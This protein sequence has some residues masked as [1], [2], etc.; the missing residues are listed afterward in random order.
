MT[1]SNEPKLLSVAESNEVHGIITEFNLMDWHVQDIHDEIEKLTQSGQS[2]D[3]DIVTRIEKLSIALA[4]CVKVAGDKY[5]ALND[6]RIEKSVA[7]ALMLETPNEFNSFPMG[8]FLDYSEPTHK[9]NVGD[10]VWA[11]FALTE[12]GE[13][14]SIRAVIVGKGIDLDDVYY[15]VAPYTEKMDVCV[16]IARDFEEDELS[17]ED[18]D[19][20]KKFTVVK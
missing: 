15:T 16:P 19:P 6:H 1:P 2:S 14:M 10:I 8:L 13:V 18:P 5:Q 11:R 4:Y 12:G 17:M 7:D 9:Y 20:K 3:P